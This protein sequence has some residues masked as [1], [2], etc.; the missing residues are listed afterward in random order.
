LYRRHLHATQL[1]L[2]QRI[3]RGLASPSDRI[4]YVDLLADPRFDTDDFSDADH[5]NAAGNRKLT[6]IIASKLDSILRQ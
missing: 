3:P 5:L 6:S 1:A 4:M 2:S